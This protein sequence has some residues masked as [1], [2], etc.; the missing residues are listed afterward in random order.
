MSVCECP[1][2]RAGT[3]AQSQCTHVIQLNVNSAQVK[4]EYSICCENRHGGLWE[5]HRVEPRS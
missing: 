5:L 2:G 4:T 3:R 1:P